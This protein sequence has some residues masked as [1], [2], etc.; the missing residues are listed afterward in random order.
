MWPEKRAYEMNEANNYYL[1]LRTVPVREERVGRGD[2][3]AQ[4]LPHR[5]K[6]ATGSFTAKLSHSHQPHFG[7]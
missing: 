4:E 7:P 3:M 2:R 6:T 5:I 1:L